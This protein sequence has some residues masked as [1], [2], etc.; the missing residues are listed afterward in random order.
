[1]PE[2]STQSDVYDHMAKQFGS[3]G[4]NL[5]SLAH[6]RYAC[7]LPTTSCNEPAQPTQLVPFA[8]KCFKRSTVC[9]PQHTS[10]VTLQVS[11]QTQSAS[12]IKKHG[13][14]LRRLRT[15]CVP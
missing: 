13:A 7:C 8:G 4:L 2:S 6:V 1:M 10:L 15:G 5:Q 3:Q 12:Y 11:A 9:C 14:A